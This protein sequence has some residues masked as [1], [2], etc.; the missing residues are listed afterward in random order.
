MLRWDVKL[1][2]LTESDHLLFGF[3]MTA[4]AKNLSDG[5]RCLGPGDGRGCR[6]KESVQGPRRG[7]NFEDWAAT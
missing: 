4:E 1:T 6:L 5:H 2:T 7:F 3:P